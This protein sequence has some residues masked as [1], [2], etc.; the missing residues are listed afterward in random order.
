MN[1]CISSTAFPSFKHGHVEKQEM[2]MKWKL[3]MQAMCFVI[4]ILYS[5]Q[6]L[7]EDWLWVMHFAFTLVLC[8]LITYLVML[9]SS[10]VH[11][12]DVLGTRLV[13]IWLYESNCTW[14]WNK[15]S[16]PIHSLIPRLSSNSGFDHLQ[17]VKE[18][19]LYTKVLFYKIPGMIAL[20]PTVD[21]PSICQYWNTGGGKAW[22]WG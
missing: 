18:I 8:F 11:M 17:Y 3:E 15:A 19:M 2:I 13:A 7:L 16:I 9:Q 12:R 22:E 21:A 1:N 20:F 10:L 14:S 5:T 4:N 6:Q